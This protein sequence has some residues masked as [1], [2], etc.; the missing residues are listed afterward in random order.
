MIRRLPGW[1]TANFRLKLIAVL[2][3]CGMWVGVVYA[4][5]PPAIG[6]FSVRVQSGG[7]LGAGLVLPRPI[8][9]VSVKV[10]GMANNVHSSEVQGHLSAAANLS[11]IT[12]P[13]VY[14]VPISVQNSDSNVWIWSA[15]EKVRVVM[16]REA[17]RSVPV[18]LTVS[19]APPAGYL[20]NVA[21]S[22]ITPA[23]VMVHGPA[24]ALANVQAEV[25][26][27]LSAVRTSL[28]IPGLVQLTNT[29]GLGAELIADPSV[30]S[31]AV[32]ISSQTTEEVLPVRVIFGGSGEPPAGYNVTG[33]QLVPFSVTVSGPASVLT[34]LTSVSTEPID[35]S[36]LTASETVSV[37]LVTPVGTSLSVGVISVAITVVPVATAT[38]TPTPSPSPTP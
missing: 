4:S 35:V 1:I 14:E 38:P 25:T 5:D 23:S 6:T 21:D 26:V 20:V 29:D 36:H 33:I 8:G 28:S 24:S 13:G 10:A 27:N 17:S 34:Q 18:H 11:K 2:V 9:T 31:V 12:R 32:D 19:A 7:V 22:T 30:V 37:E 15:P 16:D 3:A